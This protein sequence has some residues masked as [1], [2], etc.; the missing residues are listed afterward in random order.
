MLRRSLLVALLPSLAHAAPDADVEYTLSFAD[1]ARNRVRVTARAKQGCGAWWM[2]TWIP[3][4]YLI[5]EFARHVESVSAQGPDGPLGVQKTAKDTWVVMCEGTHA[6]MPVELSYTVAAHELTVRTSHVDDAGAVLNPTSWALVPADT[7]GAL[8]LRLADA[9]WP[10]VHTPI[11]ERDGA[12]VAEDLDALMDAPMLVGITSTH[13]FEVDGVPHLVATLDPQRLWTHERIGADVKSIVEVQ[14]AFWGELPYDSYQV[15]NGLGSWGGLEHDESTLV[16]A[17]RFAARFDEEGEPVDGEE[18][19]RW[20]SIVSHELFHAWN[21]RRLRPQGLIPQDYRH[22]QYTPDLW[23]AEGLTSYYD[24]LLLARA[25]LMDEEQ[26]LAS[27]SKELKAVVETPGRKVQ[28]LSQASMDA[29]VEF[30]R[31]DEHSKNQGISYYRKGALVGLVLDTAIRRATRGE[32]SLDDAM[33]LAW[34]RYGNGKGYSSEDFRAVLDETAGTDLGPLVHRLVDTTEDLPLDEALAYL[35]LMRKPVDPKGLAPWHGAELAV[36]SGQISVA[37]V[38]RDTPA[39]AAGVM[40][41]DELVAVDGWRLHDTARLDRMPVG[42]HS[43]TVARRGRLHE[44]SVT[45]V[46]AEPTPW[47]VVADPEAPKSAQRIRRAWLGER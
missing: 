13:R 26:L 43:W 16:L 40:P 23:V 11:S 41:G 30:Y 17:P 7:K 20:L 18:Y 36:Q 31:T 19:Q 46:D 28:P 33:R 27:L 14:R 42:A 12:F 35:G 8:S 21:V 44:L 10:D 34:E 1:A 3:G 32:R 24:N 38:L 29:W 15:L 25:G 2:A 9:P 5:R 6:G 39:W 45:T 22:E 37:T 47:E 4:S